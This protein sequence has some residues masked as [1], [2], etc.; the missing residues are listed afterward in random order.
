MM[1]HKLHIVWMIVG[2][3]VIA[4]VARLTNSSM[5]FALT[6][7]FCIVMMVLMMIGMGRGHDKK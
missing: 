4:L 2:M 5:L 3:I 6:P 7:L 1:N